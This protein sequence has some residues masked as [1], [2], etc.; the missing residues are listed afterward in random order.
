MKTLS[1]LLSRARTAG[2]SLG[3]AFPKTYR[4]VFGENAEFGSVTFERHG[5]ESRVL[6]LH[7]PE[8]REETKTS[9]Q[10]HP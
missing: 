9:N 8:Q 6:D 7:E 2:G 4:Y 5:E 1:G 10:P 3:H